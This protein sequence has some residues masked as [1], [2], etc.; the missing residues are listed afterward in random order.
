MLKYFVFCVT[1]NHNFLI[2]DYKENP[3]IKGV[4]VI[5]DSNEKKEELALN[6]LSKF[7]NISKEKYLWIS[8]LIDKTKLL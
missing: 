3:N 1:D 4:C 5:L 8:D 6:A 2:I 7:F